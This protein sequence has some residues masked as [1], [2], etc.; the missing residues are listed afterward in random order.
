MIAAQ[1]IFIVVV[2]DI[3]PKTSAFF[4]PLYDDGSPFICDN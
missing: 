3:A 4:I 2:T 1:N